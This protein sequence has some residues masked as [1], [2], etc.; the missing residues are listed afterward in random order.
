MY[1]GWKISQEYIYHKLP[2]INKKFLSNEYNEKD[3]SYVLIW[4][5]NLWKD[6]CWLDKEWI[7]GRF[8]ES[9]PDDKKR[10]LWAQSSQVN[11]FVNNIKEWDKIIVWVWQYYFYWIWEVIKSYHEIKQDEVNKTDFGEYFT[12]GIIIKWDKNFTP[13]K[14]K[15]YETPYR[16]F[17]W[18]KT[19]NSVREE[20]YKNIISKI[21]LKSIEE[22][23]IEK[24]IEEKES[25][26]EIIETIV[27]SFLIDKEEEILKKI[28]T[29][30]ESLV[31]DEMNKMR[32]ELMTIFWVF[33]WI[34]SLVSAS[35][36][37]FDE[38]TSIW[39]NIL[40]MLL[41]WLIVFGWILSTM[42][43]AKKFFIDNSN[44]K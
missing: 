24:S 20:D 21:K 19:I 3:Y 43:F 35:S 14:W 38:K 18:V 31:R 10:R 30:S 39:F 26:N 27:E 42:Y 29:E 28:K 6:L 44:K 11:D 40:Y 7:K 4:W 41:V 1:K 5:E 23:D 13:E 12:R 34:L 16:M 2:E 9:Y 32:N 37:W 22:E 33:A 8:Y 25:N 17:A 36:K 15:L